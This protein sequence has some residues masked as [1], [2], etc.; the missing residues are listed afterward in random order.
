MKRISRVVVSLLAF[1]SIVAHGFALE[2]GMYRLLS[3][4]ESGKMILV[5]QIPNKTKYLLDA[6]TAKISL[7]GKPAEFKDL[8]AY[9]VIQVKMELAKSTKDGIELDGSAK[10]IQI[11]D[12]QK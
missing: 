10:E 9:S 7:N 11:S 3:V 12:A 6:T 1:L 4:A 5:S 2:A 8:K